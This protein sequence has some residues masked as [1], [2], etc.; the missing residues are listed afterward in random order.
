MRQ[1]YKKI[2]ANIGAFTVSALWFSVIAVVAILV[3]SLIVDATP[4]DSPDA[5]RMYWVQA[6]TAS[7]CPQCK[8]DKPML[9]GLSKRPGTTV[10]MIDS[11]TRHGTKYIIRHG[12]KYLPTYR[13]LARSKGGAGFVE[14]LRTHKIKEVQKCVQ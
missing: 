12:I 2:L 9:E 1:R 4:P 6:C 14:I 7:W 8:R 11:D 3:G 10:Q 5:Q 13:V